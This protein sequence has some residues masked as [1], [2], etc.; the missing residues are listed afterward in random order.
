MLFRFLDFVLFLGLVYH[1]PLAFFTYL[2]LSVITFCGLYNGP[3]EELKS[4]NAFVN[5]FE[6]VGT[7]QVANICENLILF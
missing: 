7:L 4:G 6:N 1:G 2:F 5:S 3:V